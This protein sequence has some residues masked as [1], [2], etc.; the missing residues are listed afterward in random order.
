MTEAALQ[1]F[2]LVPSDPAAAPEPTP[3]PV[4]RLQPL[5]ALRA[6]DRLMQDKEDTRQV[7]EIMQALNGKSTVRGYRRLTSTVEGGR[8]AYRRVELNALLND[9]AYLAQFAPGT[10]GAAYREFMRAQNLSAEGLAELSRET[11]RKSGLTIELEHPVAWY[12]R[13]IRDSHD[14]WHVL[15]GYGRDALGELCL[16]AF[17]YAQTRSLGWAL[18]AVGGSLRAFKEKGRGPKVARAV[19]EAYRRS[20]AAAWLPGQ[21]I[22]ALLAM[23]LDVAR[24]RVGL[25]EPPAAY[26]AVPEQERDGAISAPGAT[27][28]R[29]ATT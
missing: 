9:R 18:I 28:L 25:A 5:R 1:P 10:L 20:Q 29:P 21:D 4:L 16:V 14:I 2:T 24:R 3:M 17:S 11:F 13:R 6:F 19:R 27:P 15:T 12:G 23:P 22:E 8:Q 7:F 26:L